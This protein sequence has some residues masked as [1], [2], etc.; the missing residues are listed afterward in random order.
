MK[1][2]IRLCRNQ[3]ATLSE[4][5]SEMGDKIDN[6]LDFTSVLT[7]EIEEDA[8]PMNGKAANGSG[9]QTEGQARSPKPKKDPKP[10]AHDVIDF[11]DI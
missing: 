3:V 11:S 1:R 2:E 10:A 6:K 9:G 8:K 5:V 7:K 4:R